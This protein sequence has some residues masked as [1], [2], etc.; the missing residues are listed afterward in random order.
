MTIQAQLA[1]GRVLEFPDGTDPSVVQ[2]TVKRVLTNPLAG[3]STQQLESAKSA[4]MSIGDTLKSLGSGVV[5]GGKSL[6]DFF[7]TGTDISKGLGEAQ[8]YLQESLSPERQAEIARRQELQDRA[9][10]SGSLF[11]EAKAFI[12]GVTEA[13]IQAIAQALGSSAP[14]IITGIAALP[15]SAPAALALGVGTIA[16]LSVGA[17]QGV[18]EMKGGVFDAVKAEYMKQGKTE[19][20]AEE[21]AI[22]SSE[23]SRDAAF[24]TGGAA[25]L[26]ALDAVTGAEPGIAKAMRKASPTGAMTK[27][28]ID[29]GI[30]ALPERAVKA[31]SYLGQLAKGVA[32]ESPLEGA[33]GAF[34][35]YGENVALQPT[36]ADVTP[37]QGVLGAGLRDATVGAL[38]GGAASP[39]GMKSARQDYA[40]D[41]FLRQAKEDIELDKRAAESEK[42]KGQAREGL[43]ATGKQLLLPAPSKAY[44]EP[45]DPLQ[46]P[47]GRVTEDE[48]GKAIGNNTV[49]NYLN[50]YRKDNNLPKLKSYSIEDI[51]DAMTAQ[52]P[53]GEEGALNSILAYKTGYKDETYTPEDIN[54]VAVA[55]NVA[56][57]TKGFS[58]FLTRA[59]GKSDLNK[60]TQPELH[61]VAKALDGIAPRPAQK[62]SLSYL[63]VLTPHGLHRINTTKA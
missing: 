18:G 61:S 22:K 62:S 23:Y 36:G 27:E 8:S 43:G 21:L 5:G 37:M 50:K 17:M 14:A 28:A 9:A 15:A 24:Q 6:V 63:K 19:K 32:T 57:E 2:A 55:K 54:N 39:L 26:G 3:Q 48:L 46:D 7:G 49:V 53:E 60:M 30:G 38:F 1:D 35:Q 56:T 40:T 33:Q 4:P 52:N 20:E 11:Q 47:V 16:K 29:A 25:L 41:Q 34:G 12:G 59:T 13:P 10:R 58:D 44:E 31:P 42:I 51:K 45:K